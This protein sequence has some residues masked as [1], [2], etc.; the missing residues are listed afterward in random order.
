MVEITFNQRPSETDYNKVIV[1]VEHD[2][3]V[4]PSGNPAEYFLKITDPDGDVIKDSDFETVDFEL[5][6]G[7]DIQVEYALPVDTDGLALEGEYTFILRKKVGDAFGDYTAVFDF[8]RNTIN[9]DLQVSYDCYLGKL[10]VR[11]LTSYTGYDEDRLITVRHPAIPNV[12]PVDDTTSDEATLTVD[13]THEYVTYQ[14]TLETDTSITEDQEINVAEYE[15]EGS[16]DFSFIVLETV[17]A[18]ST[19]EIVCDLDS[20]DLVGCIDSKLSDIYTKICQ[21]GGIHSLSKAEQEFYTVV[22]TLLSMYTF[23]RKCKNQSKA[24]EYYDRIKE[25]LDGCDCDCS[26]SPKTLSR[27]ENI[28]YLQGDD[29]LGADF[30]WFDGTRDGDTGVFQYG[31]QAGQILWI[32]FRGTDT[33]SSADFPISV[34]SIPSSVVNTL[35]PTPRSFPIVSNAAGAYIGKGF[36]TSGGIITAQFPDTGSKSYEFFIAIPL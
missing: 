14:V 36:I 29:G 19:T 27:A 16:E 30:E 20:C 35:S 4:P 12:T 13:L 2:G 9:A 31:V 7:E 18:S 32:N 21:A 24:R 33:F 28:V 17:T 6:T 25:Y 22:S 11:D 1:S 3:A 8:S 10:I 5:D 15:G 26:T 23:Y 34:G